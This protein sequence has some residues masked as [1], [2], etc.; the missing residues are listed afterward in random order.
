MNT[1]TR[2]EMVTF[3]HPFTLSGWPTD[4]PSGDYRVE[5]DEQL[6]EGLSFPAYR[7]TKILLRLRSRTGISESVWIEPAEF[8]A[9]IQRDSESRRLRNVK[10]RPNVDRP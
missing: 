5:T 9:A 10:S 1:R 2:S 4:L 3:R 7:R 6:L 8:D